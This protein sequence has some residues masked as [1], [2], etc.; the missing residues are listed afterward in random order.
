MCTTSNTTPNALRSAGVKSTR[1]LAFILLDNQASTRFFTL[2]IHA[3][4]LMNVRLC[5][6]LWSFS[7]CFFISTGNLANPFHSFIYFSARLLFFSWPS[8]R[9]LLLLH[10]LHFQQ[11]TPRALDP[12]LWVFSQFYL[13]WFSMA[14][15][16]P[17]WY[18]SIS[19]NPLLFSQHQNMCHQT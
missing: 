14:P 6:C 18:V 10:V 11:S 15:L 2:S 13:D 8:W 1:D 19:P 7:S 12:F 5:V 9:S 17:S 16:S 4:G 3:G